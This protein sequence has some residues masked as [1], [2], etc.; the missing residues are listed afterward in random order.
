MADR[1]LRSVQILRGVAATG[2]VLTHLV[3]VER[4]YLPGIP[5]TSHGLEIGAGGVDLFFVISG[6][7]MTSITIGRDRR[8]GDTRRFLLRRFT[9]IYPLYWVYFALVLPLFLLDPHMVNSSHGRPNPFTSFFLLPDRHLPLLMV[10]WTLSFELY[11]YLVYAC[12]FRWLDRQQSA[13]ALLVWG[14]LVA[15]GN[16]ILRP[17]TQEPVLHLLF[18]PLNLEFIAGC[19]VARFAA[20]TS[21]ATASVCLLA[22]VAVIWFGAMRFGPAPV[23]DP[24][25]AWTRVLIY[26]TGAVLLLI[27][28]LGWEAET[29]FLPRIFAEVGDASYSLYLSHILV[30]GAIGWLW[31]RLLAGAGAAD[32]FVFLALCVAAALVWSW[33][34]Y[35]LIELPLLSA[36]RRM[37]RMLD[38]RVLPHRAGV[39]AGSA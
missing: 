23:L 31:H 36:S 1:Q 22:A 10:A 38:A 6:F 15:A 19:F 8:P 5:L 30:L 12:I 18:N 25:L 33:I 32:H 11:F 27:G 17:T 16:V 4:K 3:S 7:I 34:S 26:G 20:H 24:H 21:R 35:M 37:M 29:R 39:A 9:R 14:A 13:V 28:A 2:V